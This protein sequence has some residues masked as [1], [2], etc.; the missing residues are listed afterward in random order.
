V[1]VGLAVLVGMAVL[2]RL[3]VRVGMAGGEGGCRDGEDGG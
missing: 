2:V 3:A 1:L